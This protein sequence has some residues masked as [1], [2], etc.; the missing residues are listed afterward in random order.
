MLIHSASQLLTLAGGPQRGAD[1]GRLEIIPDGAVLVRGETI[2]AV[3]SSAELRAAYP[4]EPAFDAAGRVVMP[5]LVDPHTHLVWAGDRAAEFDLRLQ[6][7]SYLDILAAG[8]GILS[9]VRATRSASPE[10]LLE[11]TRQRARDLFRHGTT[12]AEAKTGYG[13][14]IRSE[15]AQMQALLDLDAEGP[16]EIIPTFLGAHA[17]APEYKDDPEGYTDLLCSEAHPALL[18]WWQSHGGGRPLPFVDVFC[19]RGAFNLAQSRRIL[20]SARALGFG[21]KL[22]AD[23]FE[24]LGGASLAAELGAVS[25]DHLVKTSPADI[26]AMA[27]TGTVAVSLP[28]T[29]FGLAEAHYTPARDILAAG[30]LLA[31]AS[32]INP[33]TAWCGNMQFVIALACRYLR[34]TPGQAVAAAT[35]NAAAAIGCAARLGS[36]EPGKQAD[37]IVLS[38]DDYRHLGYRFGINLVTHTIKKGQIYAF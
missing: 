8:G 10:S 30:G 35:I 2:A 18:E 1:L 5:G 25:A 27:R 15:L 16:L 3:G 22:H 14:D 20:E 26:A 37:L 9:T 33:G 6:G 24:N 28:C 13:L 19:E 7:K 36:L 12:T 34:L 31:L 32:D 4:D 38:V 23:E 11:Q 17:I 21:L 29:P